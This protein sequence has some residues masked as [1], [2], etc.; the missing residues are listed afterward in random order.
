MNTLASSWERKQS[1][2]TVSQYLQLV[3]DVYQLDHHPLLLT[4]VVTQSSNDH[5]VVRQTKADRGEDKQ[6]G[7]ILLW[8]CIEQ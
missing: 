1:L 4:I 8:S 2:S 3:F 6:W 7:R 5:H